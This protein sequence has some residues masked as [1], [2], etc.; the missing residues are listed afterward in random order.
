MGLNRD[1]LPSPPHPRGLK[2]CSMYAPNRIP[3]AVSKDFFLNFSAKINEGGEDEDF[4]IEFGDVGDVQV[5][6]KEDSDDAPSDVS[7][8]SD[9]D[10]DEEETNEIAQKFQNVKVNVN[11]ADKHKAGHAQKRG[12][13]REEADVDDV[14]KNF[15]AI[16]FP[17]G[18]SERIKKFF[19][20][21]FFVKSYP[22]LKRFEYLQRLAN[23]HC[24]V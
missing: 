19:Q 20:K 4:G 9:D 18:I 1:L 12:G 7:D 15:V 16:S 24:T 3:N 22:K 2:N 14:K 5:S 13:K 10:S 21:N 6:D 23:V 8:N 11:V 17:S